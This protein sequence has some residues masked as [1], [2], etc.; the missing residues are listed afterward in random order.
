MSLKEFKSIFDRI[1]GEYLRHGKIT[2]ESEALLKSRT[3]TVAEFQQLTLNRELQ[4]YIA[5]LD[6]KIKIYEI[7]VV[8]HGEIIGHLTQIINNQLGLERADAMM[9]SGADNGVPPF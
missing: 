9:M 3:I 5:L 4:R 1:Y 7:P 6:G 8:P 2:S